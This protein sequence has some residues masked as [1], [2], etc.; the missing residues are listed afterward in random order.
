MGRLLGMAALPLG[1]RC[2]FLD[3]SA[4]CCAGAVGRHVCAPFDD[5][6]ALA[7]LT[8][9]VAAATV[10][11]E[12]VGHEVVRSVGE[13]T[14]IRPGG[15]S[16]QVGHDRLLQHAL[17]RECGVPAVALASI[18]SK[19]DVPGAL[20]S[21]GVACQ[22]APRRI[23]RQAPVL[24]A[25]RFREATTSS[26]EAAWDRLARVPCVLEQ[27]HSWVDSF[28]LVATR[29]RASGEVSFQSH[30]V[31]TTDRGGNA[32]RVTRARPAHPR[33]A[34]ASMHARRVMDE[35]DH[36]GTM[37]I[38]F[39]ETHAG[40]L[41]HSISALPSDAALWTMGGAMTSQFENTVRA[42]FGW[43]LGATRTVGFP[44]TI[45]LGHRLPPVSSMLA[46]PGAALHLYGTSTRSDGTVG[47]VNVCADSI[48][49]RERAIATLLAIVAR[50]S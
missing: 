16:I 44:A 6:D 25:E 1:V 21:V 19:A 12:T 10:A 15:R 36:V 4:A 13:R 27:V 39:V 32:L 49:S 48:D 45:Q 47:H 46:V 23:I 17:F 43:P 28:T 37:A 34:E 24:A 35:L 11:S 42:V 8:D 40:L 50:A 9:R 33:Q 2:T 30:D 26:I 29:G 7:R 18:A 38:D 22:V 5:D 20:A 41:A 31:A 3:P 14:S